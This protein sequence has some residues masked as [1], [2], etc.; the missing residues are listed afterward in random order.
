MTVTK[1]TAWRAVVFV[2]GP[3]T[4]CGITS[5]IGEALPG[6]YDSAEQAQAAAIAAM[7]ERPEVYSCAAR[8]VEAPTD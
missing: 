6:L 3:P 8:R 4:P 5:G 7:T 1:Q 2:E